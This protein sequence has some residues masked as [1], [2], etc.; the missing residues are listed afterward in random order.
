MDGLE[1]NSVSTSDPSH[2]TQF[3][4]LKQAFYN[5]VLLGEDL[6]FK[7]LFHQLN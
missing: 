1:C 2:F 7:V 3:L 4:S 5:T 6:N